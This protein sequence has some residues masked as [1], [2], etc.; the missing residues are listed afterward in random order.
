MGRRLG[1]WAWIIV[2]PVVARFGSRVLRERGSLMRAI[3]DL[4]VGGR[5]AIQR[6]AWGEA[7]DL[8]READAAGTL[9]ASE[10]EDLARS[11]W[12]SGRPDDCI[13]ARERAFSGYAQS[14]DQK[15][16]AMVALALAEDHFHRSAT[17]LGHAWLKR[18]EGLLESE[19]ESIES[20]YLTR[21]MAVIAFE[22]D[23]DLVKGLELAKRA[24]ELG[25]EFG[26]ADL[27]AISLHDQGRM[28][29]AQG[30]VDEGMA[31]M[32]E[33]M[34]AVVGGELGALAT[35]KIYCNMID[36]CEQL[37]DYRRAGDWSDAAK[38]WCERAGHSSGIPGVCRIHRAT[39][40]RLRGEWASAEEEARRARDELGNYLDFTGEAL[41]EIGEIRF[42]LGDY[43]QAEQA[44]RQAHGSGRD[45]QPGMA[46][47]QLALG[48][49]E[50][51]RTLIDQSIANT[52]A[53]LKRARLLPAQIEIAIEQE[54]LQDAS[55]AAAELKSAADEYG[56]AALRAHADQ[57][58]GAV[59]LAEGQAEQ[60]AEYLRRAT[61]LWRSIDLPFQVAKSRVLLARAYEQLGV[62]D[63]ARLELSAARDT[64]EELGAMPDL[65]AALKALEGD[66]HGPVEGKRRTTA[67]MFTDIVGSTALIGAIGDDA[68]EQL[69]RWH[70]RTLRS[71]FA[72]HGG[73]EIDNAGDGFFVSFQ[74]PDTAIDCAIEIQQTLSRQR[75]EHGFAPEVRIG[76]HAGGVTEVGAALAGE[77]VHRAARICSHAA[78]GEILASSRLIEQIEN[79]SRGDLRLLHLDGFTEM[80]EVVSIPWK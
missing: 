80:V 14:E 43:E 15:R 1:V 64:F 70:N 67:L 58:H 34:V 13:S 25:V 40:M 65:R 7:F 27:R 44:F 71:L 75:Q 61:E 68:W 74:R 20:G 62:I 3:L 69:R 72:G 78:G 45:P 36:I 29:V 28:I 55:A 54:Q 33:A 32:D 4:V 51:A 49:P 60:G 19:P 42:H 52:E 26:D 63:I 38:R 79:Q 2:A 76:L 12:W 8:L 6:N 46:L 47:L 11:A 48:N 53:P 50:G 73:R 10:L 35:G 21:T 9:D 57:A 18:A 24:Y 31:L 56:T 23:N 16:A 5:E 17:A 59:L 66:A 22:A 39:I 41:Y 77:E 37:A 30:R